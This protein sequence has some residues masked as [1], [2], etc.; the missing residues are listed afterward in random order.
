MQRIGIRE[1]ARLAGVSPTT[2]SRVLNDAPGVRPETAAR[3]RAVIQSVGFRVNAIGRS[4]VTGR[5]RVVGM[6]IPTLAN[7]VFSGSVTGFVREAEAAGF[8]VLLATSDYDAKREAAAVELFLS[9]RVA[10]V[11]L[12]LT[13]PSRA[14][15]DVVRQARVPLVLLYNHVPARARMPAVCVDDR[16]LATELVAL[17]LERGHQ[18]IVMVTGA[19]HSSDRA[20]H[21]YQGYAEAMRSRGLTPLAPVEV[22]YLNPD[23]GGA[24]RPVMTRPDRPTALFCSNDLL[25]ISVID[26]VRSLGFDVPEDVSVA[27]VDGIELG[28]VLRPRLTT[29]VLPTVEMGQA[30]WRVLAGLLDGKRAGSQ[31]LTHGL[32]P[33]GTVQSPGPGLDRTG[34]LEAPVSVGTPS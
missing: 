6:L 32:D 10:G 7:P 11:A 23:L 22:D 13:A 4:L 34:T 25:A 21:R 31:I 5:T 33:G 19:F 15:L 30:A 8:G 9:Q 16:R 14:A 2:I 29:A 24:L 27:G 1:V 17:M 20:R 28:R 18:R 3:V 26:T 12:T